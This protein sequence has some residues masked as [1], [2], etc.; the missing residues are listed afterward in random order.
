MTDDTRRQ[1]ILDGSPPAIRSILA[2]IFLL[3]EAPTAI[4]VG[5]ALEPL[6]TNRPAR[7]EFAVARELLI[8]AVRDTG[9]SSSPA[10][11][12]D[13]Y[14]NPAPMRGVQLRSTEQRPTEIQGEEWPPWPEGVPLSRNRYDE[15]KPSL[16][17]AL[18][19]VRFSPGLRGKL[20]WNERQL[21]PEWAGRTPWNRN[22]RGPA[23]TDED[24]VEAA[25][26]ISAAEGVG[27]GKDMLS[28]S[29]L[30]D[31]YQRPF[32]PVKEYLD[33]LSWDEI[34]R[35]K[36]WLA[37]AFGAD[38]SDY[39]DAAGR[40]WLISA[41]ARTY[42]PGCQADHMMVLQG[43]QGLGKS[44]S[45]LALA[46]DWG[47]EL[48]F[49]SDPKDLNLS[50]H[51]PW[52]IEWSDLAGMSRKETAALKAF[53]SRKIDYFRPPYGR[54][55]QDFPRRCVFAGSTNETTYLTDSTG[56]RR[57]WPIKVSKADPSRVADIRDQL[58]AE[59]V[60]L[61]LAGD[62]WWL[63]GELAAEATTRQEAVQVEDV[64]DD[65]VASWLAT[66]PDSG[67]FRTT[68]E[69]ISDA[70][71]LPA[72]AQGSGTARRLSAV[73]KRLGWEASNE[74]FG[75][76]RQRGYRQVP[77]EEQIEPPEGGYSDEIPF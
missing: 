18:L 67:G 71:Q 24:A 33:S 73:M 75:G 31:A 22:G 19:F 41:V 55:M 59:A 34:P 27:F 21:R 9:A 52:I 6:R 40:S 77:Q 58:W 42:R 63:D 14:L 54:S 49:D 23:V 8:R 62:K 69:L 12:V 10:R 48:S 7:R 46:S 1:E 20:R 39:T 15:L 44:Q 35:V 17:N 61:Y 74:R 37:D 76:R 28:A 25:A 38:E 53:I 60:Q 72:S 68:A 64:W 4:E 50:V 3:G 5:Q 51:G 26:W 16:G 47:A 36:L 57:Y 45:M 70:L 11:F 30:A 43:D 66:R 2:S 29:F 56:G 13:E 32:D 65:V